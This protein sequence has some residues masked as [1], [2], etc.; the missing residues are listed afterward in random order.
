MSWLSKK[1]KK[2]LSL[3]SPAQVIMN[4]AGVSN[5]NTLR[6]FADP[7]GYA[8]KM[9]GEGKNPLT[10]RKALDPGGYFDAAKAPPVDT[11]TPEGSS[12]A[13]GVRQ[14]MLARRAQRLAQPAAAPTNYTPPEWLTRPRRP[15][16]S[17]PQ[18]YAPQG[19][20]SAASSL[21]AGAAIDPNR[22]RMLAA[23]QDVGAKPPY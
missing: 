3:L 21:P 6:Q 4:K 9:M 5:S 8:A 1:F 20:M 14:R 13:D 16:V 23:M 10:I 11:S 17:A 2:S 15:L 7:G 19:A 22:F 18:A 12:V